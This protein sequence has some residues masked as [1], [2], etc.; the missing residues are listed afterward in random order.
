MVLVVS[1]LVFGLSELSPR[2][3]AIAIAG[4]DATPQLLEQIREEHGFNRAF[5]VRY[6]QWV[7]NAVQGDLGNSLLTT[8]RISDVITR[9]LPVSMS[10]VGLALLWS[11]LVA[12]AAGSLCARYP[13]SW[14]DRLVSLGASLAV[15]LPSFCLALILASEMAVKRR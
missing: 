14:I 13:G 5:L 4:P 2:D 7:G 12:L 9:A 3:P 15:G 8:E 6:G 1:F 10:L 11:S